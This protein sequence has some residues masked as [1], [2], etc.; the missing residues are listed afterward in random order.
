MLFGLFFIYR[1][2][3]PDKS[4]DIISLYL[5]IRFVLLKVNGSYF[6]FSLT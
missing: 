6:P 2:K 4:R 3:Y 1:K 5:K